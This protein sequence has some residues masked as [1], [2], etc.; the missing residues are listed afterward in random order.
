MDANHREIIAGRRPV[1]P[2]FYLLLPTFYAS[3]ASNP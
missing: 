2:P 3:E 1:P